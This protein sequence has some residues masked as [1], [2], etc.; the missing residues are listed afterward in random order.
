MCKIDVNSSLWAVPAYE[1]L[2]FKQMGPQQELKGIH[3]V[4]MVKE[5]EPPPDA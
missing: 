4:P 5:L 3:F 2:G 1:K